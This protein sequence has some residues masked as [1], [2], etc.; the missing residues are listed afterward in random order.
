LGLPLLQHFSH[1]THEHLQFVPSSSVMGLIAAD[2]RP[3]LTRKWFFSEFR[4]LNYINKFSQ[5]LRTKIS[6]LKTVRKL[7]N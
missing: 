6:L 4:K 2:I 1:S 3:T 7:N 5:L